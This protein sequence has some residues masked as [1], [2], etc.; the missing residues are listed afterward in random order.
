MYSRFTKPKLGPSNPPQVEVI[1][2]PCHC[3]QTTTRAPSGLVNSTSFVCFSRNWRTSRYDMDTPLGSSPWIDR[4]HNPVVS[5]GSRAA[6]HGNL[7]AT[8]L[9]W[10]RGMVSSPQSRWFRQKGPLSR[11]TCA[12]A[13]H[14]A[15]LPGR[16]PARAYT[17]NQ[18][19]AHFSESLAWER[20][21]ALASAS[22]I[23]FGTRLLS[24]KDRHRH[25]RR[26][27]ENQQ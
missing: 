10:K 2:R 12:S 13:Y 18:I 19:K 15:D 17:A 24:R 16:G 4:L 11:H 7:L 25:E 22:V 9:A 1:T 26:D 27:P 6:T 21:S 23:A 5:T 8:V 3:G 14:G 20:L